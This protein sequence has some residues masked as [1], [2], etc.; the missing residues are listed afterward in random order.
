MLRKP[1]GNQTWRAGKGTTLSVI[2]LLKLSFYRGFSIATRLITRGYRGRVV[3][4]VRRVAMIA[5]MGYIM[6]EIFRF[7]GCEVPRGSE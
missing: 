3:A 2:F 7:P 1:S 5:V 6:P 4:V